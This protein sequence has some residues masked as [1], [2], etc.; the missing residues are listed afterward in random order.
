MIVELEAAGETLKETSKIARLLLTLPTTYDP[1]VT[2]IQTIA[3]DKLTLPFVKTRLLDYEIKLRN[4]RNDTSGKVLQT[5]SFCKEKGIQYHLTVPYTPQQNSIAERMNKSLTEKARAMRNGA[6]LGKELWGE[7]I[8]TAAYLLNLSPTKALSVSKTP[9]ELWHNKKARLDHLKV[10]GSTVYVLNKN[11]KDGVDKTSF[12]DEIKSQENPKESWVRR[13]ARIKNMPK[14]SYNE[15]HCYQISAQSVVS[16]IPKTYDEIKD[17]DDKSEWEKAMKDEIASLVENN[18]WNIVTCPTHKNVVGW[19]T[20]GG[21]ISFVSKGY[22]ERASDKAIFEQSEL[23]EKL[24][25]SGEDND[26]K[27][28]V[29]LVLTGIILT[30]IVSSKELKNWYNRRK[31]LIKFA[32]TLPGPPTLPLIGNAFQ[33][34]CSPEDILNKIVQVASSYDVPFRFWLGPKLFVGITDPHDYQIILGSSKASHKDPVYRFME[35]FIGKGLVSGSGPTHR[36]H[37]KMI[38]PMLSN[39]ALLLF[40]NYFD[41]HSRYCADLLEKKN[42]SGE[43]DILPFMTNC[44]IDIIFDTIIGLPGHSQK[45]GYQDLVYWTEAMYELIH[46][47]MMKVWLH[48]EWIFS[49]T[50]LGKKQKMGQSVI[51]GFIENAISYKK[52][53]HRILEQSTAITERPRLMLLEQLIDHVEKTNMKINDEEIRDEIYTL[54]TAAQDTTAVISSFTLLMLAMHSKVQK[55]VRKELFDVL[56]D[57]DVKAELLPDLRYLDLVIRETLRL[58]PIAP[59][60]VRKIT[61]DIKLGNVSLLEGISVVMLPFITHRSTKFWKNPEKFEP[62]RFLKENSKNR[63]SYAYI[64]FSAGS[65][66]CIGQKYALMCLKIIIAN[67]IRRYRITTSAKLENLRLKADISVRSRDGYKISI[68]KIKEN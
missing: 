66:S 24:E 14:I 6:E 22:G 1:V 26:R 41:N 35:P 16:E 2:A 19:L 48:P 23:I 30:V 51:R 50:S 60:M 18:T 17:R 42:N 53:E 52:H 27:Q 58:Y 56:G 7:A 32:K 39:K 44:T 43:F 3:D 64:P 61:G 20:P 40:V 45:N 31:I 11:K 67:I 5:E 68:S 8:L 25:E 36:D 10:F 4:E 63:H 59:L 46:L 15:E 47:R 29:I 65:R 55:K 34:S 12:T 33:F 9:Y 13:S 57:K 38:M 37:R 21:L 49:N 62:E 54:F 28:A